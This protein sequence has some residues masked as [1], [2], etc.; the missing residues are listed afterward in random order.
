MIEVEWVEEFLSWAIP[1][2]LLFYVLMLAK[3]LGVDLI[4]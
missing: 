1:I 3:V 4:S 2:A